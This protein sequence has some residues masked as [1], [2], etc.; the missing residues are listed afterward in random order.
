MTE[1][2]KENIKKAL[3]KQSSVC[4]FGVKDM[5]LSKIVKTKRL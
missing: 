3:R 4:G 5:P 2:N 1:E